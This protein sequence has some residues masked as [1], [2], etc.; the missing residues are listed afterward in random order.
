MES[1]GLKLTPVLVKHLSSPLGLSRHIA[2]TSWTRSCSNE[3]HNL[4]LAAHPPLPPTL[5]C[6]PLYVP[7]VILYSSCEKLLK[8]QY[9]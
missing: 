6:L 4:H 5:P 3:R 1:M 7:F 9:C 8:I 2:G